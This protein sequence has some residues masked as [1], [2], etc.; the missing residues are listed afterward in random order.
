MIGEQVVA[1][2]L[3]ATSFTAV[4]DACAADTEEWLGTSFSG[5]LDLDI[6]HGIFLCRRGHRIR[7]EREA[8]FANAAEHGAAA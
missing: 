5:R 4:C 8:A 2:S 3:K 1:I 6:D 7:V